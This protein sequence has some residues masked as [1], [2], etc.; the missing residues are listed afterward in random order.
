[1]ESDTPYSLL[2]LLPN[3]IQTQI[4][5]SLD[6]SD[7]N[8]LRIQE[9]QLYLLLYYSYLEARKGGKRTTH[10]EHLFEV[11][12]F[13]NLLVLEKCISSKAYRPSRSAAHIIKNPVIREIF[14][15][16]FRDR[17]VHHL[18]FNGVYEWWD[19]HFIYDSYSCRLDK[20]VLFGIRRLEHHIRSVT[21]EYGRPAY[22]MKLDIR[23]YFM[24]LSRQ[25]L[26]KRAIWGLDKQYEGHID[27][28][29]YRLI[30]YLW[31]SIIFDDPIRGAVKKGRL[32]DWDLLPHSKS[33]FSQPRGH[34]IVIG[35]LTSQLLSNIYLDQLDRFV[36]LVLG[37]KHYGRYVDDFYIVV[38]ESELS[39]LKRDVGA[40]GNYL[41][42]IGLTL[43]P[44]KRFLRKA[45][46]GV[47]FL[48]AVVN[49][50]HTIPGR[51]LV[52]N[53]ERAFQDVTNGT[54]DITTVPS[55]I[56]HAMH[57]NSYNSIKK[58]FE[59]A[60]WEYDDDDLLRPHQKK[61]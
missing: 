49:V 14:A 52:K 32:L 35:N 34:G 6:V 59:K 60:G 22:V 27:S 45:S 11:N 33:L 51:R 42:S 36:T 53:M 13:K 15:A 24:S 26:Y 56:G 4:S 48:G 16:P 28:P 46:E 21:D 5:S 43:H 30:K 37:Y 2:R 58:A 10:D 23:G 31:H 17:I 3:R 61:N 54:R 25:K 38:D 40:I 18:I 8:W 57:L 47:P 55:Y 29:E 19:N 1:M 41:E 44:N 20:G 39:Q 12:T 50:H 9:H 7:H